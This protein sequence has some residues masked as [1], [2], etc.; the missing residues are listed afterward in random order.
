MHST[1]IFKESYQSKAEETSQKPH[2]KDFLAAY[3]KELRTIQSDFEKKEGVFYAYVRN[4]NDEIDSSLLSCQGIGNC[5]I[6][7]NILTTPVPTISIGK[8]YSSAPAFVCLANA[9]I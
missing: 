5:T 3:R 9:F 7:G 6:S 4:S 8:L 2:E 1:E